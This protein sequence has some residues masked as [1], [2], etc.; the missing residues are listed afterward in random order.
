V[1]GK[2]KTC[3]TCGSM[4]T[5]WDRGRLFCG[6]ASLLRTLSAGAEP[7]L[8]I[9]SHGLSRSRCPWLTGLDRHGLVTSPLYP[10]DQQAAQVMPPIDS[11]IERIADDGCC[12]ED[13]GLPTGYLHQ[14]STHRLK[15]PDHQRG[16]PALQES[17]QRIDPEGDHR[18]RAHE[19][20][21]TGR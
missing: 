15:S 13:G 4:L 20:P 5:G 17:S 8:S 6:S 14:I 3:L 18:D 2:L 19:Q 16:D 9:A 10:G 21:S 1:G 11:S 7:Q 12:T